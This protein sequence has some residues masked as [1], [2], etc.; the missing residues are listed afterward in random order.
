MTQ[1]TE[2]SGARFILGLVGPSFGLEG[3]VKV[4]PFSGETGHFSRL[5]KVTLRQNGEEKTWD[6]AEIAVRG[7]FLLMRF[8]GIDNPEAAESLKGAQIVAGR[9]YAAPLNEGE[10][11]VDDLKGLQVVSNKGETLGHICDVVDGGGGQLAEVKLISGEIR[12]APFR[13][14]FFAG[15]SLEEGRIVLLEPWILE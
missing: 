10:Y 6:L 2:K 13:K 9:E 7:D 5:K 15:I 4:K 3:F 11:Y 8:A 12:F 1:D 14:E